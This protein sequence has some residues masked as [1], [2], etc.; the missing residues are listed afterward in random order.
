MK[1]FLTIALL[2]IIMVPC[3]NAQRKEIG[4]ARTFIKSGKNLDKAEQ[5]MRNLLKDSANRENE[6]I[7][8]VL[9]DA[10]RKQYEERNMKMYLK[11]KQDTA[12]FFLLTRNMFMAYESLDSLDARPN[13][14]GKEQLRYREKN[15]AFL[16]TYRRN[17]YNGG[18]Y[19]V[20]KQQYAT[21]YDMLDTYID[22]AR[23]PLFASYHY[24]ASPEAAYWSLFCGYKLQDD[25]KA[26]RYGEVALE[27]EDHQE[28]AL[29]Y[30]SEIYKKKK[31]TEA[32]EK[33]LRDGFTRYPDSK[34]F[35]TYLIDYYNE[36][37][38]PD[39]AMSVVNS[40]LAH[41]SENEL[42]L[43]AKSNLL[44]NTGDYTGC[45]ALCDS[46]IARNDQYAD[47]YY[48]AGLAYINM[49]LITKRDMKE[50]R[51]SRRLVNDF[52]KKS[53]PYMERYRELAPEEKD[54]WAAALYNIYLQLN[55]GKQFE[56]ID[57]LLR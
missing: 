55:M 48:N 4:Q 57:K 2:L 37:Q 31:A 42:Y 25:E 29:E 54:K 20:R 33:T 41:D 24:P 47:A 51:Q 38:Q 6:K 52:Y 14:K 36:A 12:S 17:L 49:A 50:G 56:E 11:Q 40:A 1:R 28:S 45:I 44:L 3:L 46:L 30:L 7:H 9:C 13:A 5:L 16:N 32:Y 18:L 22:C 19:F 8:V 21:A 26:L 53:M 39:S 15:A 35:F 10:L 34:F 23:Q 27:D 43:F